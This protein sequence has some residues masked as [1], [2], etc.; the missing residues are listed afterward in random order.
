MTRIDLFFDEEE[1]ATRDIQEVFWLKL[2]APYWTI[3]LIRSSGY[4]SGTYSSKAA[5]V[6]EAIV[7]EIHSLYNEVAFHWRSIQSHVSELISEDATFL[8]GN[9]FVQLLFESDSFSRSRKY[10]WILGSLRDFENVIKQGEEQW[11]EFK[12][13]YIDPFREIRKEELHGVLKMAA[14]IDEEV[15]EMATIRIGFGETRT[16]VESMRDGVS[17]T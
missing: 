15:A 13:R 1:L 6:L 8:Q 7:S 17:I 14:T 11:H 5:F 16:Q 12:K 4:G 3:I 2:S 9:E 10:F